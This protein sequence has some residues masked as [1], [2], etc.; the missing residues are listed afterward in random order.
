MLAD[1]HGHITGKRQVLRDK[2]GK[3]S[4]LKINGK[5]HKALRDE[6]GRVIGIED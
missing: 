4:G 5:L 3:V 6:N 1:L 2:D